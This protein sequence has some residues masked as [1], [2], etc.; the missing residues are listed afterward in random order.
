[1]YLIVISA[2][3]QTAETIGYNCFPR[4][5]R[6][7]VPKYRPSAQKLKVPSSI[8]KTANN[9]SG[10]WNIS[11]GF[12]NAGYV[13]PALFLLSWYNLFRP[14][15]SKFVLERGKF[16]RFGSC[17]RSVIFT[18]VPAP[19]VLR[20]ADEA[21]IT[22]RMQLGI[23]RGDSDYSMCASLTCWPYY[24]PCMQTF[25]EPN[26]TSYTISALCHRMPVKCQFIIFFY[27]YIKWSENK[28]N[29]ILYKFDNIK[30][31]WNYQ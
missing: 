21:L 25:R 1:M 7:A 20:R 8:S 28:F 23:C 6:N 10:T 18:Q 24:L 14:E 16:I 11:S 27:K 22:Y 15:T 3:P 31:I 9:L 13:T 12:N 29:A 30:S 26:A 17:V 19:T 5:P 4:R 2:W